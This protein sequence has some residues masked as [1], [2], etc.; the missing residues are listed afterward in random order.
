MISV[1][2]WISIFGGIAGLMIILTFK[3]P[4]VEQAEELL[5]E[6]EVESRHV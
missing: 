1:L 3:D 2:W 6:I 5:D 4:F